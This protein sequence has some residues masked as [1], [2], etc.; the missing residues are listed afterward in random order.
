[1]CWFHRCSDPCT[2]VLTWPSLACRVCPMLIVKSVYKASS[3]TIWKQC[4][5]WVLHGAC[6]CLS[7]LELIGLKEKKEEIDSFI[8][9]P[10]ALLLWSNRCVIKNVLWKMCRK[11][12]IRDEVPTKRISLCRDDR[13][14]R[15]NS[16]IKTPMTEKNICHHTRNSQMVVAGPF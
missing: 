9:S 2:V 8:S 11:F 14:S 3:Q 5:S 6:A 7:V 13:W 10:A 12:G 16:E 4:I 15:C 1:M